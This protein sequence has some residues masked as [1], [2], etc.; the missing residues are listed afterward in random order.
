[1][2]KTASKAHGKKLAPP[3]TIPALEDV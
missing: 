3:V 2:F 1:V